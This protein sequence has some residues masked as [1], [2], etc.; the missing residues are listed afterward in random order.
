MV[1]E[2]DLTSEEITKQVIVNICED[3]LNFFQASDV[4]TLLYFDFLETLIR[5]AKISPFNEEEISSK[6]SEHPDYIITAEKLN[7]VI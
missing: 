4:N 3:T 1:K 7:S 2:V 6:L 5:L